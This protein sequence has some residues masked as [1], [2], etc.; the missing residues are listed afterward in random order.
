MNTITKA[1][2]VELAYYADLV[3][4]SISSEGCY[5]LAIDAAVTLGGIEVYNSNYGNISKSFAPT[6]EFEFD[7][8]SSVQITYGGVFVILPNEPY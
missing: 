2:E 7:D 5:A 3:D 1:Q 4:Y 8:S 6:A